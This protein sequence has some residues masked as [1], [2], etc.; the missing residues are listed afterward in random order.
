MILRALLLLILMTLPAQAERVV[1]GISADNIGITAAFDG[2]SVLIFGAV[3]RDAPEPE[4]Q[5]GVIVTL[6]GPPQKV[7]VRR[8]TRE[9][10]IWVNSD[11][12]VI[13]SVPSFYAVASSA[14]LDRI[15]SPETDAKEHISVPVAVE[16]Y[17]GPLGRSD[18]RPFAE[19]LLRLRE[20][21]GAYSVSERAVT[22]A[23]D[24]LFR[25]DF[26]LPA[27]LIEGEYTARMY[28]LRE[29]K[30]IDQTYAPI[31]VQRI[32]LERFTYA[33]SREQPLIYG[34]MSLSLAIFAGWAAAAAF[35]MIRN[36]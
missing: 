16:A 18:G 33:L 29:G 2:S 5:L 19:A 30:V 12:M 25:A 3:K 17:A 35:R 6:E 31:K 14:P 36:S 21:S 9:M 27:N 26:D 7:T 34:L 15:L 1:A 4:G 24:T 20:T 13:S 10:G 23:A 22:L 8:K 11:K 28:L 32:G